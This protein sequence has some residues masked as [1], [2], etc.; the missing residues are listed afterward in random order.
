MYF[1]YKS[2]RQKLGFLMMNQCCY[3]YVFVVQRQDVKDPK[4]LNNIT[5]LAEQALDR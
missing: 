4:L 1:Q 3:F 2:L 5:K